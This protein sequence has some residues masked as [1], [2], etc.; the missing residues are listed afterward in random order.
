MRVTKY[1]SIGSVFGILAYTTATRGTYHRKG[2]R[3]NSRNW[4]EGGRKEK[5]ALIIKEKLGKEYKRERNGEKKRDGRGEGEKG[6]TKNRENYV[7][8]ENMK[9]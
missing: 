6:E 7:E 1:T 5:S 2:D 3:Q 8:K 4:K 9:K